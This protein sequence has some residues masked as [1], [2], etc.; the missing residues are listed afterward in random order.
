VQNKITSKVL[1]PSFPLSGLNEDNMPSDSIIPGAWPGGSAPRV[2][3]LALENP[4]GRGDEGDTWV[5]WT[6]VL[7]EGDR[8]KV[9]Q[10]VSLCRWLPGL[11]STWLFLLLVGI[12][13][14]IS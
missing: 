6:W 13:C 11:L 4:L 9:K 7:T 1:F 12:G 3:S 8:E 5:P 14:L 2:S 10:K